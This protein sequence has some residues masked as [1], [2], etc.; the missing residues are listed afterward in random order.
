MPNPAQALQNVRSLQTETIARR[1]QAQSLPSL[2]IVEEAED[3]EQME[4][5]DEESTMSASGESHSHPILSTGLFRSKTV[6]ELPCVAAQDLDAGDLPHCTVQRLDAGRGRFI[7][8]ASRR[9]SELPSTDMVLKAS[10]AR[11]KNI[12]QYIARRSEAFPCDDDND[13]VLPCWEAD[14]SL[15]MGGSP[16]GSAV[17]T[18]IPEVARQAFIRSV[19]N[20]RLC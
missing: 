17:L 20:E 19:A 13:E 2:P 10:P 15:L 3:P 14:S 7:R 5:S 18:A 11:F 4:V 1:R 8:F 6:G 12:R 16:D 9:G